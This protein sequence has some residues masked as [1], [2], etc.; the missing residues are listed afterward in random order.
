ME[1]NFEGLAA[2]N[3]GLAALGQVVVHLA[4]QFFFELRD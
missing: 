2:D 1:E 3:V 4:Q